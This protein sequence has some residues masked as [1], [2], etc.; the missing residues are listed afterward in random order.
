[1]KVLRYKSFYIGTVYNMY[2]FKASGF[3]ETLFKTS[4]QVSLVEISICAKLQDKFENT[5]FPKTWG[6]LHGSPEHRHI[7]S[8]IV[9]PTLNRNPNPLTVSL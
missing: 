4:M 6:S 3:D 7:K 1:M 5:I 2:V 9:P 8:L